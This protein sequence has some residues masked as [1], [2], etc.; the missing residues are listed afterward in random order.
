LGSG[1]GGEAAGIEDTILK[2]LDKK[3]YL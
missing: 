2:F 3:L 1:K